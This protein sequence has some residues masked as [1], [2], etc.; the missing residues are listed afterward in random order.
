VISTQGWADALSDC[1]QAGTLGL[2]LLLVV[3]VQQ[4]SI[5][6]LVCQLSRSSAVNS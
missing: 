4:E 1:W 5:W 3:L 2:L 6:L